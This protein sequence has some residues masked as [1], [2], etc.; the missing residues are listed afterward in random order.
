[1]DIAT[2]LVPALTVP[3]VA[4][5]VGA[6]GKL[7]SVAVEPDANGMITLR[8]PF[9]FIIVGW[10]GVA[11]SA[12]F[13]GGTLLHLN[14]RF[15]ALIGLG[16]AVFFLPMGVNLLQLGHN[17]TVAFND[18][19]LEVT[20]RKGRMEQLRWSDLIDGRFSLYRKMF[21][22][23]C[24][25]LRQVR[26]NPALVGMDLFFAKLQAHTPLPVDEL[27]RAARPRY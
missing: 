17:H 3:L 16:G 18:E 21:V 11:I 12:V 4:W 23:E 19:R 15:G 1:M 7:R 13:I 26:V 27:R 20:D 10:V 9:I 8:L 22:F 5:A 24:G 6:I 2:L 14:D 25:D